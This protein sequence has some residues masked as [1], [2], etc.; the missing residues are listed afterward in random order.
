MKFVA[1]VDG[2]AGEVILVIHWKGG[3]H[4]ELRLAR[5]RRGQCSGHTSKE[6]VDAVR[7]LAHTCTDD[8]IAGILN[9][10]R[11]VTGHGNR[12]TKE[13]VTSLRSKHQISCYKA[14]QRRIESLDESDDC[15]TVSGHQFDYIA[16]RCRTE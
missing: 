6:I 10:N 16:S 9:R 12:W 4:T 14:G 1:D 11:L 2:Q 8:I 5:R 13:L 15:C 7:V 3:V